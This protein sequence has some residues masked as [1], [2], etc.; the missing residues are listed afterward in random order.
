MKSE[1]V[2]LLWVGVLLRSLTQSPGSVEYTDYNSADPSTNKCSEYDI[3]QS[4]DEAPAMAIWGFWSTLSLPLLPGPLW[5]AVVAPDRILSMGQ[6]KKN[7]C[8]NKWMMLNC[9]CYIAILETI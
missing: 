4:N 6:I 3:K 8:A 7:M 9:D 2:W 5:P 1:Q